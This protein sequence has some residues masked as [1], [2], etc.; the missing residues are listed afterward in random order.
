MKH[1]KRKHSI[2][3][4]VLTPNN[5]TIFYW[6]AVARVTVDRSSDTLA[7]ES[8]LEKPTAR[9]LQPSDNDDLAEIAS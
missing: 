1:N 8:D 6:K 7:I 4:I 5:W 9:Q 2:K 3:C